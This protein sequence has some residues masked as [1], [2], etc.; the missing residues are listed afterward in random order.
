M[1]RQEPPARNDNQPKMT[2]TNHDA[3]RS[4]GGATCGN[5]EFVFWKC[6]N[7]GAFAILN[8][9]IETIHTD[10]DDLT[11]SSLYILGETTVCPSCGSA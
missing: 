2:A 9:E 6:D 8:E 10:A 1:T 4:R 11:Q 7:C 5:D 3:I